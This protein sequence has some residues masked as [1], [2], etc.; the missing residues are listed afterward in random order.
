[1][2]AVFLLWIVSCLNTFCFYVIWV[3]LQLWTT[4]YFFTCKHTICIHVEYRNLEKIH[5]P[6]LSFRMRIVYVMCC[7][8]WEAVF[9]DN[10]QR[11]VYSNSNFLHMYFV[12]SGSYIWKMQQR[13][14]FYPFMLLA[15]N[16][17]EMSCVLWV[18]TYDVLPY[19]AHMHCPL[20][21]DVLHA[22][23]LSKEG[24]TLSKKSLRKARLIVRNLSFK[25]SCSP[26]CQ[27][28]NTMYANVWH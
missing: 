20:P 6:S 26:D 13:Q 10:K 18:V 1:M 3:G 17:H 21:G 2:L 9:V 16:I 19:F 15:V 25:V 22:M 5:L 11:F 14:N 23:L 12:V 24:K 8:Y 27:R 28:V 7:L 4:Q